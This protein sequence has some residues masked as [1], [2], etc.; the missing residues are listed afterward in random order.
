MDYPGRDY[1][2]INSPP[3]APSLPP[4]D[5]LSEPS[6]GNAPSPPPLRPKKTIPS[7][8]GG[9]PVASSSRQHHQ[10][11]PP[12]PPRKSGPPPPPPSSSPPPKTPVT[13]VENIKTP[14]VEA[15]EAA[16]G[17]TGQSALSY[18]EKDIQGHF[19]NRLIQALQSAEVMDAVVGALANSKPMRTAIATQV[20]EGLRQHGDELRRQGE[21]LRRQ[22]DEVRQSVQQVQQNFAELRLDNTAQMEVS[23]AHGTQLTEISESLRELTRA[24]RSARPP[25]TTSPQPTPIP[26]PSQ[27]FPPA[28]PFAPSPARSQ[29]YAPS[30]PQ[31]EHGERVRTRSPTQASSP[32][33]LERLNDLLLQPQVLPRD[34][35]GSAELAAEA[36]QISPLGKY[37]FTHEWL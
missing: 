30:Q 36:S 27:R 24:A 10:P 14:G 11:Y 29:V 33:D 4:I 13:P 35:G 5:T 31:Q 18:Y 8:H 37:F 21:E 26:P 6:A 25:T 12:P 3:K 28:S 15:Q 17:L 22:G 16:G 32:L 1:I 23:R 20:A 7:Q 34:V 9:Q 19:E 2:D